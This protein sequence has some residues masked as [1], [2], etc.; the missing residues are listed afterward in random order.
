VDIPDPV[1][2]CINC[3]KTMADCTCDEQPMIAGAPYQPRP[4]FRATPPRP[5]LPA[6]RSV[7]SEVSE[8]E[9]DPAIEDLDGYSEIDALRRENGSFVSAF[10]RARTEH[11]SQ[12]LPPPV[13]AALP[14]LRSLYQASC[15]GEEPPTR[16]SL[17]PQTRF[18]LESAEALLGAAIPLTSTRRSVR[19]Q[20]ELWAAYNIKMAHPK[21]SAPW[22]LRERCNKAMRPGQSMHQFG[23]AV[24][25]EKGSTDDRRTEVLL[26]SKFK[27]TFLKT[28]PHHFECTVDPNYHAAWRKARSLESLSVRWASVWDKARRRYEVWADLLDQYRSAL[29]RHQ[30]Q[31]AKVG[32]AELSV[33][34]KILSYNA[35]LAECRAK[36][37]VLREYV[38]RYNS[39]V[40][41]KNAVARQHNAAPAEQQPEFQRRWSSIVLPGMHS[42]IR[43][44]TEPSDTF[45]VQQSVVTDM[46]LP[47]LGPKAHDQIEELREAFS[48]ALTDAVRT[49]DA[50]SAAR[51]K[52]EECEWW[53][54]GAE[55]ALRALLDQIGAEV[56]SF[57][58]VEPTAGSSPQP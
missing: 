29:A 28:E 44:L 40:Q 35:R 57:A 50:S 54:A 39:A 51:K 18:R 34:S 26:R 12:P 24:D 38:E 1:W 53:L 33:S 5:P 13:A 43:G 58:G 48:N 32:A 25:I 46:L 36:A 52:L 16:D 56:V 31:L 11:F 4:V 21:G 7:L 42:G 2:T 22:M 30:L 3:H 10:D 27:Q 19:R 20:A 49:Y 23:L 9:V 15:A 6:P 14:L 47:D 8:I 41:R 37:M 45:D 17:T 55:R